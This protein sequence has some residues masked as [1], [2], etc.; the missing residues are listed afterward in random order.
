MIQIKSKFEG[1]AIVV[2]DAGAA[3]TVAQGSPLTLRA[4]NTHPAASHDWDLGD[5]T[6]ASGATVVHAF[7][8]P[9]FYVV[10]LTTVVNQ[11]GGARTRHFVGVT[12]ANAPPVVDAGLNLSVNE[13]D[14]VALSG[15]FSD[16][17]WLDQHT[18][19]WSCGDDAPLAIATVVEQH[20]PPKGL[21][22]ATAA[23]AWGDAGKYTTTLSVSDDH[24]GIGQDTA[25]VTVANVPPSVDA[26][27]DSYAYPDMVVT[28]SGNFTDPG[29]LN[30][31]AGQWDFG[32]GT[33]PVTATIEETHVP[34]RGDGTAVASHVYRRRGKYCCTCTVVD[35][36]GGIGVASKCVAVVD[37][38]NAGL[39]K[40]FRERLAG[41]VANEWEP[42]AATIAEFQSPSRRLEIAT[43]TF[44]AEEFVVRGGQRSQRVRVDNATRA[45]IYQRIGANPNWA[46]QVTA[47]YCALERSGGMVRLGVD[48]TGGVDA[49]ATSVVWTI[50]R[51]RGT[52]EQLAVRS[53][54]RANAIT[55]FLEAVGRYR[56]SRVEEKAI[57]ISRSL[58]V[59]RDR[60]QGAEAC[61]DGVHLLAVQPFCHQAP[62]PDATRP[63]QRDPARPSNLTNSGRRDPRQPADR[64]PSPA[65]A[66]R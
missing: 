64:D 60:G 24:G 17:G 54:A 42:Y 48:P 30:L 43:G 23:H 21:G 32:D 38:E 22:T 34:P 33:P 2:A 44:A 7:P 41:A 18:A 10:K 31:H 9:G 28:L 12:V 1:T 26:G 49:T 58:V 16:G 27:A 63:E 3:V 19:V 40:G 39:E 5:G 56:L 20:D 66:P 61:F 14:V 51:A 57:D 35:D 29:W 8:S 13:G 36:R 53:T 62:P 52:W 15:T 65:R 46:Y 25:I 11:P 45:G 55:I 47:W 59:E 6:T 50:G 37:V 4:N